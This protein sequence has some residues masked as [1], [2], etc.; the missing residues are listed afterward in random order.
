MEKEKSDYMIEF[1]LRKKK[2]KVCL[3]R[4]IQIKYFLPGSGFIVEI[5]ESAA[6][7]P[8]I[9]II[10]FSIPTLGDE[11]DFS[12]FFPLDFNDPVVTSFLLEIESLSVSFSRGFLS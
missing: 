3:T 4:E 10:R 11:V 5:L 8:N 9:L 12:A 1:I 7:K 2:P 6:F